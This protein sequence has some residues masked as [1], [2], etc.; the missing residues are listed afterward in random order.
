V[1]GWVYG[2]GT[3]E[4]EAWDAGNFRWA[5]VSEAYKNQL[6]ANHEAMYA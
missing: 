6:A 4:V 5:S 2:I 3:G 1:H